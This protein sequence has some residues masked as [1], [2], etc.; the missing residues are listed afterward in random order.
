MNREVKKFRILKR[1]ALAPEEQ[2]IRGLYQNLSAYYDQ[3][4][5][6]LEQLYSPKEIAV[7]AV[8]SEDLHSLVEE[9]AEYL[10]G[11]YDMQR[12]HFYSFES[13]SFTVLEEFETLGFLDR[14]LNQ[15]TPMSAH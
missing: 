13:R 14:E 9:C 10:I 6:V 11:G 2:R 7:A 1:Y 12:E 5:L 3:I 15:V 4:Q 8:L